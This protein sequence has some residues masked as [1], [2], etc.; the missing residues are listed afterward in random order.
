MQA[1]A[2]PSVRDPMAGRAPTWVAWKDDERYAEDL[3]RFARDLAASPRRR[4]SYR[5]ACATIGRLLA[6]RGRSGE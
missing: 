1:L 5:A 3:V 6:W 4:T 2:E